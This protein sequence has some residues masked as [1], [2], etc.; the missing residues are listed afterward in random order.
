MP[1]PKGCVILGLEIQSRQHLASFLHGA[2]GVGNMLRVKVQ[3]VKPEEQQCR[4][5]LIGIQRQTSKC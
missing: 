5:E 2:E 1:G 4:S 3:K